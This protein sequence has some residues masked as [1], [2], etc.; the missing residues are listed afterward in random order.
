M[1]RSL[2]GMD[3][4]VCIRLLGPVQ[5]APDDVGPTGTKQQRLLAVLALRVG[6]VVVT[7]ELVDAL[8]AGAPPGDPRR[9][10]Q[11]HVSKLRGTLEQA[12]VEATITHRGGGYLLDAA[13]DVVDAE[14]CG[15][16]VAAALPLVESA[17]D[18]ASHL[19]RT[20]LGHWRGPP[21]A[22]LGDGP[23]VVDARRR[24]TDLHLR[25][26]EA[27]IAAD[28]VVGGHREV[29]DELRGLVQQHPLRE[30]LWQQ[31]VR[32]L[33]GAGL[34]AEALA[35]Y[36]D[37][38]RVLAEQLGAD[39]S[40]ELQDLHRQVLRQEP[41]LTTAGRP[42]SLPAR[43]HDAVAVLPF[44]VVGEE[45][46]AEHLALGLHNDLLTELT[47]AAGPL[48][49]SRSSVL[50]YRDTSLSPV[51]VAGELGVDAIVDGMVQAVG[52][53]VR[54]TVQLVDG[55]SG[56]QSW[57]ERYDRELT[58][59]HLFGL[60]AELATDV[61]AALS[62]ELAPSPTTTPE[63]RTDDLEA[64]RSVA[65]ARHHFDQK[66]AAGLRRAVA[67]YEE[68]VALDPDY[69]EAWTG[70]GD[71]LVSLEAY[72]HGDRGEVL[73]RAQRAVHRAISLA[74]LEAGARTSLGVLHTAHQDARAAMGELEHALRIE[75]GRADAQNW[76]TWVRLLVGRPAIE[77]AERAVE[78]DPRNAEAHAHLAVALVGVGRAV[79]A[80]SAALRAR[81]L[82]PYATAVVYEAAARQ[83]LQQHDRI[84]GL[85]EPVA[86]SQGG[87]GVPWA[88]P[89]PAAMLAIS[90]AASGAPHRAREVAAALGTGDA[91]DLAAGLV[92][93]A[94]G[95]PGPAAE[96]FAAVRHLT[97]WS[98]LVVH[99]LHRELW[100][101]APEQHAAMVA[102][103]H[104][105]WGLEPQQSEI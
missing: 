8:W 4:P 73:P 78:L 104:R 35:A 69:V 98:C 39:P 55:H 54:L 70:L 63:P 59:E 42:A 26:L 30:T 91:A 64:W 44:T 62:A 61:A 36:D 88:E 17:P 28:L 31:L 1:C 94:L 51:D 103:A 82:S 38:R 40:P 47:R 102:V 90:H 5:L 46:D 19:L 77:M 45:P 13:P 12:D 7:D 97:A 14:Y 18:R 74:P 56:A 24:L 96:R 25:A 76:L 57:A 92:H 20:A 81:E 6:R 15:R 33:Y 23:V 43:L 84:I 22:G 99:Q 34:Q 72:G 21:L 11:V 87:V 37:A 100:S 41:S 27:R 105:S 101:Q 67:G 53:R 10:L 89:G 29:V 58:A 79:D 71:A 93:V 16:L 86:H 65:A 32:S 66:T 3:D 85:L 95:E 50:P 60:Q 48:V 2:I 68:A 49:V 75:P 52:G 9:A 80:V 83:D